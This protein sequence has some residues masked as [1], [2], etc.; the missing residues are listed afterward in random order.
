[1]VCA[2]WLRVDVSIQRLSAWRAVD[3][4]YVDKTFNN[5][6]WLKVREAALKN[7]PMAT[8]Q[9]TYEAIR[10]ILLSLGDPFT[11]F[12][13][14][15]QYGIVTGSEKGAVT[16]VG[17]EVGFNMS[18]SGEPPPMVIISPVPDG[19]A[20][21]AGVSTG[22][23]LVAIDGSPTVGLSLYEAG[24]RL[25][26][27]EGTKVVLTLKTSGG[28]T[29]EIAVVREKV[30]FNPV[31]IKICR[32]VSDKV[33]A[34]GPVGY[35]SIARFSEQ[36]PLDVKRALSELKAQGAQ[37]LLID[38]RNNGGG[39]FAAGVE[40]AKMLV[41]EGDIVLISDSDGVRDIYSVDGVA[42][43]STTPMAILVNKG[44]ASASEVFAG[45]VQDSHR[46]QIV[47]QRTFGKG[48]I[49]TLVPL[50][51][52]SGLAVTVAKYQTPSGRD[53]NKIG[54][55]PDVELP[56]SFM[57]VTKQDICKALQSNEAPSLY[58]PDGQ[59]T[60]GT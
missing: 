29:K 52:G 37:Q 41:D 1:M 40:V 31:A 21:R 58:Q 11:R 23:L 14:P 46:G 27:E 5:Q 7:Y 54:I 56:S 24:V 28:R 35:L 50:S 34:N 15:A 45:A 19:P 33:G 47:G 18:T 13:E 60:G 42:L 36:T 30:L 44:T 12:F 49:Q 43:D 25:Q 57:S 2:R 8:R 4:A 59:P 20:D 3:R 51:D 55:V 10:K 26:G 22:D 17:I 16:G 48:L 9:E 6:T 32:S 39:S 38:I 53:I